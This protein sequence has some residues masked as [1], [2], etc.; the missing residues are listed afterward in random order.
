MM[1]MMMIINSEEDGGG[2]DVND[3]GVLM[4]YGGEGQVLLQ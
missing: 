2:S 4:V 1:M 3:E